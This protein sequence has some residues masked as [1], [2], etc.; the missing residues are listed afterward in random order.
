MSVS[1]QWGGRKGS[2]TG[3]SCIDDRHVPGGHKKPFCQHGDEGLAGKD[4]Q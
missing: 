2:R 3:L 1:G 4:M